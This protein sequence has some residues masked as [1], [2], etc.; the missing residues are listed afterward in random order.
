MIYFSRSPLCAPLKRCF[1][2]ARL[3]LVLPLCAA[4][5]FGAGFVVAPAAHAQT[6]SVPGGDYRLGVGDSL[7]ITVSNHPDVDSELVVRPD[8]KITL[9]RAGEIVAAGKT[10]TRLAA[11][12]ERILARTLNNARVRIIV[13]TTVVQQLS[14]S[15]AVRAPGQ[16]PFKPGLRVI[17]VIGRAGGLTTKATRIRGRIIRQGKEIPFDVDRADSNPASA[18]NIPVRADDVIFLDA[19]DFA[20]QITVTGSIN[21]PGSY[22]YDEGLT[23]AGLLAQAGGVK[24]DAALKSASILRDNQTIPFDLSEIGSGRV[25]ANS[26]LTTFR[27]KLGDVLTVPENRDRIGVTGEIANPSFYPLSENPGETTVLRALSLAGGPKEGADLSRVTLTRRVNGEQQ[28][29]T[30]DAA[31]IQRGEAPDNT[32]LRPD[33]ILFVPKRNK[34]V[35]IGGAVARPG[36]YPI[37]DNETLISA[38]AKAGDPLKE[39][40]LR[41]V[42]VVRDGKQIP[43]DLRPIFVEGAL[44]PAVAGF[45]LQS[46]DVIRVPDTSAQVTVSGAV[47]KP[48]VYALSD[49][50]SVVSLLAQAGNGA[51]N[52]ALGKAYV[53]RKGVAI[54]LDLNVFLR[55]DT[56]QP[57]LTGF[58]LQPGDTLVVPTNK[59]FYAVLGQ[60]N[61]PGTFAYPENSNDATVLNAL[62]KAGGPSSTVGDNGANLKEA[63]IVRV[64]NGQVT[65]LPVDLRVLLGDKKNATSQNFVLQP[66]DLL[67]IPSKGRGFRLTDVLAPALALNTLS[68]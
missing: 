38:L 9:P 44:D 28:V 67:Y 63:R 12:I 35:T 18:A 1:S 6:A 42:S 29:S 45:R 62:F 33:D 55:G 8:G 37:E 4:T 53:E 56:S 47:A 61:N 49:D 59:V 41:R 65:P 2:P 39:A 58:R 7:Q 52:A 31:A 54:P 3:R 21:A 10:T 43:I 24:P 17:D 20:K 13:K 25:S 64:V 66:N 51:D 32:I 57:S 22:D 16:F 34:S 5:V 60:V 50:L 15:G 23:V 27:L 11:E 40:S 46:G 30:V 36:S 14:I 68:R 19:Q 26:P 48:G